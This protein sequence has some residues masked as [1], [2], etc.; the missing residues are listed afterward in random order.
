MIEVTVGNTEI[1]VVR[2]STYTEYEDVLGRGC[3][4]AAHNIIMKWRHV[5]WG[6]AG[7]VEI[8]APEKTFKYGN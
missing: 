8:R 3:G 2:S 5:I 6:N 1:A 4:C 7:P